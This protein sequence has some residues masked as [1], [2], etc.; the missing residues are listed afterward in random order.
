MQPTQNR[1]TDSQNKTELRTQSAWR[2]DSASPGLR[3]TDI[4]LLAGYADQRYFTKMF[5][6]VTGELP[7]DYRARLLR[8]EEPE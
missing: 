8:G 3:L 1:Q 6:R 4:S 2:A 7:R 5:K